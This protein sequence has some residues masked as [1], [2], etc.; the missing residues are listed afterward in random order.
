MNTP[1]RALPTPPLRS[2]ASMALVLWWGLLAATL[3]AAEEVQPIRVLC[4]GDSITQ[5]GYPEVLQGL[6]GGRYRVRNAGHS[7]VT[8]L[9]NAGTRSFPNANPRKD[10][11][12]IVVVMLGTND[13]KAET[14]A[15]AKGDFAKDYQALI[16]SF[17]ALPSKPL[18]FLAISPP[19]FKGES[20]KGFSNQNLDE[21]KVMMRQL[22]TDNG[23]EVID[24]HAATSA[25]KEA[26]PDGVHP[27][28]AGKQLIASAVATAITSAQAKAKKDP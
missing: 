11:A 26:F 22:V 2:C 19:I 28:D 14:W 15:V 17:K 3:H 20:G 1:L 4:A 16:D 25:H 5:R 24:V 21:A 7:G 6:L 9:K 27:D 8:A 10:D 18:I 12:D 23:L 13:T